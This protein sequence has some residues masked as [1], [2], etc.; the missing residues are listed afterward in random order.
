[1]K[2]LSFIIVFLLFIATSCSKAIVQEH[3]TFYAMD[4]VITITFYDTEQSKELAKN[5]E[6][7]YK[8]YEN[9]GYVKTGRIEKFYSPHFYSAPCGARF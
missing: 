9:D 1:M 4:T 3:Y 7:I 2:R 5:V 6:S 8:K